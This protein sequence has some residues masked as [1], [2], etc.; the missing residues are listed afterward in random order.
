MCQI[1]AAAIIVQA[2]RSSSEKRHPN[3]LSSRFV[4]SRELNATRVGSNLTPIDSTTSHP[5][6]TSTN[7]LQRVHVDL[8][9]DV[10]VQECD[11]GDGSTVAQDCS[12]SVQQLAA[13]AIDDAITMVKT[14]MG[15]WNDNAHSSI[16]QQYMG[17]VG[18]EF[19][20]SCTSPKASAWI[21]G[22]FLKRK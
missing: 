19:T 16:L 11:N 5:I 8:S 17:P 21:D 6:S 15:I 4:R 14:V 10:V 9:A 3:A 13:Q 12:C 22:E 7:S 20:A 1:L 18:S 2:S